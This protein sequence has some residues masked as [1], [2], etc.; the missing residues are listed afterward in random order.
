MP[1]ASRSLD[2]AP[3][4]GDLEGKL[5]G[6]WHLCSTSGVPVDR[7]Q[8]ME[9]A[10]GGVWWNLVSDGNGGLVRGQGIANSVTYVVA[11]GTGDYENIEAGPSTPTKGAVARFNSN[12]GTY[13]DD[14]AFERNPKRMQISEG[15]SGYIEWFVDIGPTARP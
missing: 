10:A 11:N 9:L 12:G 2:P 3:T 15:T 4:I 8:S 6:S 13:H 5:A 14:I 1:R 7:V